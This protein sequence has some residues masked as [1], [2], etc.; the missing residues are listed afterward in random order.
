MNTAPRSTSLHGVN[1][2]KG[3]TPFQKIAYLSLNLANNS[4][5]YAGVDSHLKIRDFQVPDINSYWPRLAP[6]GSPTRLLCDLFWATLPWK[7]IKEEL[8]G[9]LNVF[10]TG[11]GTGRYGPILDDF[12]GG[13]VDAYVGADVYENPHWP[14]LLEKYPKFQFKLFDGL[15]V[16]AIIPPDANFFM[17]QSAIEHFEFDLSYFEQIAAHVRNYGKPVIQVH[18]YPSAVCLPLYLLHGVRQYTPRTTSK[19]TALFPGSSCTL[20]RMGGHWCS[21]A[22]VRWLTKSVIFS[23]ARDIRKIQAEAEAA[24]EAAGEAAVTALSPQAAVYNRE[25]RAAIG[26]DMKRPQ[27]SPVFY[28]LVIHSNQNGEIWS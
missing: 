11:C 17:T 19:I 16:G 7:A 27:K 6:T 26:R 14:A 2:D 10:D 5:A 8:G 28:G 9:K 1:A 3:T 4:F 25:V 22:T 12:T 23:G 13:L 21:R 20:F 24:D 15:N 18:L